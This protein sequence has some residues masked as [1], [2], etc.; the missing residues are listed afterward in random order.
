MPVTTLVR[1]VIDIPEQ[2]GSD[3]YVLRLTD[4]TDGDQHVAATV[5][6][7][8][9][10]DSLQ[11]NFIQAIDLVADA[12]GRNTS[13]AAYL[14]GSF[15]SGKSHFMAVLYA[16]LGNH[17]AVRVPEF[18]ELTGHYDGALGGKK[19]LRLTY[20]LLG[21]TSLE[22]AVLRGY[23]HQITR[24]H[25]EAPLPAVHV[26]D[27]LLADAENLR[28][29]M[30]DDE[31][32]AGLGGGSG[33]TGGWTDRGQ[34]QHVCIFVCMARL[35]VYVPDDLAERARARGLNVSAL[36]QA[37]IIAELESTATD[38]WLEKLE[39]RTTGAQHSDVLAAIDAARD[40]FGA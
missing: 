10:T 2:V 7:Y 24:L 35:N 26:S 12:L 37:A 18:Q 36:T 29:K 23:V 28:A 33:S 13:R 8:V 40:E 14:T 27:K 15:G 39:A 31:F 6:Q 32:L 38:T 3:D 17:Q 19:L 30:G 20:H 4:S 16:L 5:D 25:P 21:A 22:Q 1:D 34:D 11:D 9:L